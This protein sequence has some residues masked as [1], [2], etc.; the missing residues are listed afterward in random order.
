MNLTYCAVYDNNDDWS[1]LPDH[2]VP[3][4]DLL[5]LVIVHI[6]SFVMKRGSLGFEHAVVRGLFNA[7]NELQRMFEFPVSAKLCTKPGR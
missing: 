7:C 4:V 3:A 2:S 5:V 1:W 6:P